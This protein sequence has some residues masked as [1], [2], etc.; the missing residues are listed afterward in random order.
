M[1][2][3]DKGGPTPPRTGIDCQQPQRHT[4]E[5][6]EEEYG[7]ENRSDGRVRNA[8]LQG[9]AESG[10]AEWRLYSCCITIIIIIIGISCRQ[11]HIRT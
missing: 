11:N 4:M 9:V 1:N 3:V 6:R 10:G 7:V 2:R 8:V 5:Q